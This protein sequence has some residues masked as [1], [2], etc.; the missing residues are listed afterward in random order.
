MIV[1][2]A[3][4]DSLEQNYKNKS[5]RSLTSYEYDLLQRM[6]NVFKLDDNATNMKTNLQRTGSTVSLVAND[7][8]PEQD[9]LCANKINALISLM[10][11]QQRTASICSKSDEVGNLKVYIRKYMR[12]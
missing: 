8:Q 11:G 3:R 5:N 1:S 6:N 4:F 12:Y 10:T 9:Q 7:I 2:K